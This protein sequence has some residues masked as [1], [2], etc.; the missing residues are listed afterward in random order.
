MSLCFQR[1]HLSDTPTH[2][3]PSL[4]GTQGHDGLSHHHKSPEAVGTTTGYRCSPK[5]PDIGPEGLC[6]HM[7]NPGLG[8]KITCLHQDKRRDEPRLRNSEVAGGGSSAG[9]WQRAYRCQAKIPQDPHPAPSP[10]RFPWPDPHCWAAPPGPLVHIGWDR[11][12]CWV[13]AGGEPTE[14]LQGL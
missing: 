8:P 2:H 7:E 6:M 3:T 14:H 10:S 9:E 12:G 5:G 1:Q 13:W 4:R 11:N